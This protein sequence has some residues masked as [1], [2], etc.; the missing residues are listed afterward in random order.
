MTT[1][2]ISGAEYENGWFIAHNN[3]AVASQAGV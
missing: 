3:F 2:G 1:T